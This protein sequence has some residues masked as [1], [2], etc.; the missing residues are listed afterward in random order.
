MFSSLNFFLILEQFRNRYLQ[1]NLIR[2]IP[3]GLLNG[4]AKMESLF[5]FEWANDRATSSLLLTAIFQTTSLHR[6]RKHCFKAASPY[7]SC[8]LES[9]FLFSLDLN[10]LPATC[11]ATPSP[12][13]RL[14]CF[15][16]SRVS[17]RCRSLDSIILHVFTFNGKGL[18]LR[19]KFARF[20]THCWII[21]QILLT[22]KGFVWFVWFWSWPAFKWFFGEWGRI[23][24]R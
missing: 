23:Y 11:K 2:A 22:C 13:Y 3:D 10:R 1:N 9:P 21:A 15:L 7:F 8:L 14:P 20:Q 17:Y 12:V 16:G 19:T 6:C 5:D 18:S 4:L 24:P